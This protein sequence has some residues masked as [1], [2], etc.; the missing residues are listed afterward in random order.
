M[1]S[2]ITDMRTRNLALIRFSFA[3]LGLLFGLRVRNARRTQRE[4]VLRRFQIRLATLSLKKS[5]QPV[6]PIH[7]KR[8]PPIQ[9]PQKQSAQSGP[10]VA[11][12]KADLL[13]LPARRSERRLGKPFFDFT[14]QN[15][16]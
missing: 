11:L 10:A 1:A 3:P 5:F 2:P 15:W 12:A 13:S 9:V 16:K 4:K 14:I 8:E 6:K 7:R